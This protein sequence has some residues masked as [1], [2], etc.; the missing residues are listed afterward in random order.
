[1]APTHRLVLATFGLT[2]VLTIMTTAVMA[3]QYGF[4]FRGDN[5]NPGERFHTGDHAAGIQGEGE[6]MGAKRYLG[7]GKWSD[8]L[9]GKG[10]VNSDFVV[11]RKNV[12]AIAAGTVVGCWRNAPENLSPPDLHEKFVTGTKKVNGQDVNVGLIPGGGNMLFIDLPDGTRM[13]YAHMIPDTVPQ[14]LCPNNDT[15]FPSAMTIAE[16][17]AFLM[18]P[19]AKQVAVSK[20]QLLGQVGNSGSSSAPH[21]HIHAEKAGKAAIMRF[22]QGMAKR[23]VET[24]TPIAGGW[25]SFAG[26]EIPDGRVLIRPPRANPYRMADLEVYPTGTGVMYAGIFKPG[27]QPPMAL[28]ENNWASFLKGWQAIEKQGYRMK[29]FES[30]TRGGTRMFAGVFEPG[31]HA[32]M[33]LFKGNWDEFVKGWQS[34]ESKGYRII[35]L[36]VY[37]SGSSQTW[38]G[39]FEPGMYAPMALFKNNWNEF[40]SGWQAIEKQNYRMKDFEAYRVGSTQMYAGVFEPGT[41]GPMALFK[42]DWT[43]FL[44]GWRDIEAKGYRMRD[45]EAYPSGSGTAYAGIFEPASYGPAAVFTANDW[46]EFLERWQQLE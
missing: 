31:T 8:L 26:N 7:D 43:S 17:D 36:E 22:E 4:M 21:L 12:Y 39:I 34:I 24:N 25:T 11:Y 30:F 37:G 29:D 44:A 33:A 35:D 42:N 32:P 27:N 16:G 40:L 15:F 45:F 28:F 1:M 46:E 13:L 3:Q 14:S 10:T 41:Y 19:A 2:A 18:L 6:D 9:K 23:F 20:G 38:A 5:L